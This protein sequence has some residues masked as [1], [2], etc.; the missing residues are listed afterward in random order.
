MNGDIRVFLRFFSTRLFVRFFQTQD[1]A[2]S[3]VLGI[4]WATALAILTLST[5]AVHNAATTRKE[6]AT[7]LV[8]QPHLP[9][10]NTK[11]LEERDVQIAADRLSRQ[12][13]NLKFDVLRDQ[14]LIRITSND[15]THFNDW[16]SA[17]AYLDTMA[18]DMHWQLT[19]LCVGSCSDSTLMSAT[20]AG[21]KKTYTLP[22]A[23]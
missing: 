11:P 23:K 2:L 14:K 12:F 13:A 17:V 18:P 3:V 7:A 4:C 9:V 1:K 22:K 20:I 10:I 15:G 19:S 8:S 21:E 6:A 16:V 5:Y